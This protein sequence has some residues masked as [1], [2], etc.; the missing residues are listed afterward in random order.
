MV[1]PYGGHG[2]YKREEI[3]LAMSTAYTGFR[4]AVLE[5]RRSAGPDAQVV[6]H[7]GFWG[8]GAFGGDRVLMTLLQLVAAEVA[9]V[10][11]LMFYVGHRDG[12][13]SVDRALALASDLAP[14]SSASELI[15]RID[16]LGMFWGISDGN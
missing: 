2:R 13:A 14:A 8:C 6:I 9:G 1:A 15:A 12:R 11:R 16:A 3:E 5:S 7:S 10:A 4:A